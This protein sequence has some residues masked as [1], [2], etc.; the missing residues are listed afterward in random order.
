MASKGKP[1]NGRRVSHRPKNELQKAQELASLKK[2]NRHLKRQVNRLRRELEKLD[3]LTIY[4]DELGEDAFVP[5]PE[6]PEA[7][8][9]PLCKS[10]DLIEVPLPS[11]KVLKGCRPCGW[12][13]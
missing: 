11:G 12:R 6:E 7:S 8:R 5:L 2:E 9:C 1:V 3:S 4:A 13:N 10:K